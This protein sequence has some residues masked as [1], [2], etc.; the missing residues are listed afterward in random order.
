VF[1]EQQQQLQAYSKTVGDL[2]LESKL[3]EDASGY[4]QQ[5]SELIKS[6]QVLS[7]SIPLFFP[8]PPPQL[9]DLDLMKGE[10]HFPDLLK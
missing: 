6:H 4:E 8:V 5:M 1:T 9:C 2:Q 10:R 7:S 3:Q